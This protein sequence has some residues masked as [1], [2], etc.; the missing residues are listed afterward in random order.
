LA[1][2]NPRSRLLLKVVVAL[3]LI[4]ALVFAFVRSARQ[5]RA[6]AYKLKRDVLAG[7]QVSLEPPSGPNSPALLLRAPATLGRSLFDQVFSRV[8]ESLASPAAAG[9]TLVS[10][11]ELERAFQGRADANAL[12]VVANE[13]GLGAGALQPR[14]LG[15]RRTSSTSGTRQLYFLVFDAPAFAR[16][17]EQIAALAEPGRFDPTALSPAMMIAGSDESFESWRPLR[18]DPAADCQAPIEV[19]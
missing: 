18:V 10:H 9:I 12:A 15:Y 1:P 6:T 13:V 17:R 2:A 19:E 14:C 4:A 16:F 5:S 11:A 8:M 7:W 3:A